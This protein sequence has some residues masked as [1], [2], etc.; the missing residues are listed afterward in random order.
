MR[1]EADSLL[2]GWE[3]PDKPVCGVNYGAIT[4][5][6]PAEGEEFVTSL[7][8][9]GEAYELVVPTSIGLVFSEIGNVWQ[10]KENHSE[11]SCKL[12][13]T[14]D[15]TSFN[16]FKK[17]GRSSAVAQAQSHE[18]YLQLRGQFGIEHPQVLPC[19]VSSC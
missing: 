17:F 8:V 10:F 13:N 11:K 12:V 3:L 15:D 19:D 9:M 18:L 16:V 7:K 5:K 1:K 4:A 6:E 14:E 2:D